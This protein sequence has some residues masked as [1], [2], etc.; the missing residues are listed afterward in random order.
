MKTLNCFAVVTAVYIGLLFISGC[1]SH[2]AQDA[3]MSAL[4][5]RQDRIDSRTAARQ[6]RW[7]ERADREDAR[8]QARFDAM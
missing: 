2:E 7:Q 6:A 3:R 5:R 4:N 8:S 1:A